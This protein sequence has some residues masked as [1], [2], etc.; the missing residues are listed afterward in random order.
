MGP[1][2]PSYLTLKPPRGKSQ[3][4]VIMVLIYRRAVSYA[5]GR[6]RPRKVSM[7]IFSKIK[8]KIF[9]VY[10]EAELKRTTEQV[11]ADKQRAELR[12]PNPAP[13]STPANPTVENPQ[14]TVPA[15]KTEIRLPSPES[16]PSTPAE[17][18]PVSTAP[19]PAAQVDVAASLDKLAKDSGEDL[20]W[21][22]S[23][24]D[25]MKLVGLDSS[26]S[27]RKELADELGYQGDKSDSAAMNMWL[28]KQVLKK[29][30]ENGGKVPETL[31]V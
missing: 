12:N 11:I 5:C 10:P 20:D 24:V 28:H 17:A 8:S 22:K 26:L 23:I 21:K 9:G 2:P 4:L 25:L 31:I 1:C 18:I 3:I 29:L 13:A 15:P 27:A 14:E 7:S 6:S 30:S 16:A 19:S